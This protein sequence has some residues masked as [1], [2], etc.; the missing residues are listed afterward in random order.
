[1]RCTWSE[2]EKERLKQLCAE[3]KTLKRILKE[4]PDKT[5]SQVRV[6]CKNMGLEFNKKRKSWSQDELERFQE[7]WENHSISN[8]RLRERYQ[9]RTITALRACARRLGLSER[10]YDDSYLRISDITA[11]MQVSKDRVRAWIKNGLKYHKS[12]IKP[13]RYLIDQDDLLEYLHKHPS[14][15]DASKISKYIFNPEPA[16]LLE[17]RQ[18]DAKNFRSRSKHAEYYNDNECKKII[19]MFK[20]GLSNEDIARELNRTEYGIERILTILNLSRKHY[21][22][23]ELDILVE[24]HDKITIDEIAKMLPL[25][26]RAGIIDKCERMHL[27]YKT[28]RKPRKKKTIT[29]ESEDE[30]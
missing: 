21:N 10:P 9:N 16:W 14:C 29:E 20:A 18:T 2:A 3:N 30:T 15:Y 4:F 12:H 6:K 19:E 25:R 7:D 17:K 8:S 27:K 28:V 11:E 24:Y 5:E 13:V 22:Q 26:T 1:M 23:Y